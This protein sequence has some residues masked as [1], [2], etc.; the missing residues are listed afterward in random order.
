MYHERKSV[1][2]VGILLLYA[3]DR[4]LIICFLV[5]TFV[6]RRG[7]RRT[8][9]YPVPQGVI[10]YQCSLF[11]KDEPQLV[12]HMR[13]DSDVQDVFV[14][15]R[16]QKGS[17][18]FDPKR[19]RKE[20]RARA[21]S[22]QP[23][24][25]RLPPPGCN[26]PQGQ[27]LNLQAFA[28]AAPAPTFQHNLHELSAP[29]SLQRADALKLI[30]QAN[31]TSLL[32]ASGSNTPTIDPP[33][34]NA[35]PP[36][37]A[38]APAASSL[39]SLSNNNATDTSAVQRLLGV[40]NSARMEQEMR[41]S[42]E[43]GLQP[44]ARLEEL[45]SQIISLSNE[46]LSHP[47]QSGTSGN[48]PIRV[49][50][51]LLRIQGQ[52]LQEEQDKKSALHRQ[53]SSLMESMSGNRSPA[54][55]MSNADLLTQVLRQQGIPSSPAR[56]YQQSQGGD[57]LTPVSGQQ[58]RNLMAQLLAGRGQNPQPGGNLL[59]PQQ[60]T[61]SEADGGNEGLSSESLARYLDALQRQR[62]A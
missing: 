37:P 7:F 52:K 43:E 28:A 26:D 53:L 34:L 24:D 59:P 45:L 56:D 21:R 58:A 9:Q 11:Q 32:G 51:N 8:V 15:H 50:L 30:Q 57:S 16:D 47:G 41:Q 17:E 5:V 14:K 1:N 4:I 29:H 55:Q 12:H 42:Q 33:G 20:A 62:G 2:V 31:L 61:Q 44:K 6:F 36:R 38:A 40:I 23:H 60:Q 13:M 19:M 22:G 25:P 3:R 10:T 54:D 18:P 49:A 39:S 35:G 27:A 46:Y 48:E